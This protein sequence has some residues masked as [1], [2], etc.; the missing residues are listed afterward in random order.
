MNDKLPAVPAA[1][2]V[3]PADL[4]MAKMLVE[5]LAAKWDPSK[6]AD[7]YRD[8]LMRIIKGKIKGK[9]VHLEAPEEPRQAEVVDLM[10]RLRQSLDQRSSKAASPRT[11]R[12]TPTRKQGATRKR[13][14]RAA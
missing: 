10:E 14:R 8:N 9:K 12:S 13:A 11:R 3:R 4:G 7:E 6:Y 2:S 5:S 1:K